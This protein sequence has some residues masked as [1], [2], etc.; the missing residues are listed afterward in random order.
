MRTGPRAALLTTVALLAAG[1]LLSA[2]GSSSSSSTASTRATPIRHITLVLDF[3]P[4]AVHA[5]IY[6]ALAAGYYRRAHIDLKIIQP[7]STASTLELIDAGKADFGL[8]DPT[9][10]T[11]LVSAGHDARAVMAIVQRPLGGLIFSRGERLGSPAELQG[12]TV[13]TTGVPS[14]TA[15]LDTEVRAAGGD[16]T[17]VHTTDVGFNGA[18]ALLSGHIAAFTGFWA[19]DG[20]ALDVRGFP[21]STFKLDDWGGPHYPGLVAFTS[22]RTIAHDPALVRDFVEA[23]VHGYQD[24]L[25]DPTTS[26]HDLLASNRGLDP[27]FTRASLAQYVQLFDAGGVPMGSLQPKALGALSAWLFANHLIA[28]PVPAA[29]LGTDAFL[30]G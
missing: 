10:V 21:V 1:E 5:G 4:N 3:L 9:D 22:E 16:P 15:V 23:T 7:N 25:H 29:R 30:P 8:A 18:Q 12:R 13:G 27:T 17:R 26:L 24:T 14:D 28:R 2:C 20:V 11:T 19:A 6:R